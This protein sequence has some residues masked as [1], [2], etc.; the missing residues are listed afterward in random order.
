MK[1]YRVTEQRLAEFDGLLSPGPIPAPSAR[2]FKYGSFSRPD[3]RAALRYFYEG[4]SANFIVD[5]GTVG[6]DA[7]LSL[8]HGTKLSTPAGQSAVLGTDDDGVSCVVL[9]GSTAYLTGG[10]SSPGLPY[11]RDAGT[12]IFVGKMDALT[13]SQFI[14][15]PQLGGLDN[16]P[17][18][19]GLVVNAA[20]HLSSY[21]GYNGSALQDNAN[22]YTGEKLFIMATFSTTRGARIFRNNVPVQARTEN[23]TPMSAATGLRLFSEQGSSQRLQGNANIVQMWD[24]DLSDPVYKDV[25]DWVVQDLVDQYSAPTA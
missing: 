3:G 23:T 12:V 5:G 9:G 1:K 7:W 21:M 18:Y 24:V 13:R 25:L 10:S 11:Y 14:I 6:P 8:A 17:S 16:P 22:L 19:P 15:G 20:G 2:A 4:N